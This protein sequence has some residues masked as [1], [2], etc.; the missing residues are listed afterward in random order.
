M[1][2]VGPGSGL[3]IGFSFLTTI[4]V[5]LGVVTVILFWPLSLIAGSFHLRKK[6]RYG[7]RRIVVLGLDGLDPKILGRLI[8]K[9]KLPNF[10]SLA[11]TGHF[12]ELGTTLPAISPAAWSSFAVGNDPSRH[13]IYGFITRDKKTYDPQL[14]SAEVVECHRKLQIGGYQCPLSKQRVRMLRKGVPFWEVLGKHYIET[15]V[16][17]VPITYPPEPFRGRLLSGMCVPDLLGGQGTYTLYSSTENHPNGDE[18]QRRVL[19]FENGVARTHVSG[20]EHPFSSERNSLTI[21]LKVELG[22]GGDSLSFSVQNHH[23]DLQIGQF[24]E[25]IQLRFGA[26]PMRLA[27]MVQFYVLSVYPHVEIYM[28]SVHV[29]PERPV[30]AI[31]HP[32]LFSNYLAKQIGSF[33]T[34]GLMEDTSALNDG[35]LDEGGFLKQVSQY[36]RERKQ[37]FF[38]SLKKK[39]NQVVVC[40]FDTPDRVQH[41]FWRYVDKGHPAL[42]EGDSHTYANAI[43]ETYVEMD[44]LVGETVKKLRKGTLLVVMSDHGFTS[45]RRC[46]NL[47]T[48]LHHNGYLYLNEDADCDR[49]W[50]GSVDWSRT[51]AYALGLAG[52]FLNLKGR[53]SKG[54]VEPGREAE[55]LLTEIQAKL[56]SLRDTSTSAPPLAIRRVIVTRREMNGPYSA[57]GPD[58]LVAY[59]DGYRCSWESAKGQVTKDVFCDNDRSWSGDHCVDPELVPGV[60]LLNRPISKHE[61]SILDIAP[62]ILDVCG[63]EPEIPMQGVSLFRR[64]V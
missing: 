44:R 30:T 29:A 13:G 9:G 37:M 53:E 50:L 58:L 45:F 46:V 63:V 32:R 22:K 38:S 23:F 31:S 7:V 11:T 47:N 17:R 48:W 21:P 16:L 28:S 35:V 43:D 3:A 12:S 26:G 55:E 24:S 34:L 61:P 36:Y 56:Q 25:W 18:G 64:A 60:V 2:Y 54:I 42:K 5:V 1:G 40:V 19:K 39:A 59:Q 41:M 27:G 6:W 49:D 10:E 14:S 33:G 4:F 52:I 8:S 15:A 62:T 51:R 20:P 57:E